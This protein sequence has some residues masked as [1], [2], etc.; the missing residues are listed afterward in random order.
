VRTATYRGL[1]DARQREPAARDIGVQEAPPAGPETVDGAAEILAAGFV[2]IETLTGA[3]WIVRHW[4]KQHRRSV[5]ETRP[6]WLHGQADGRL[7]F[8]RSPWD[9]LS[10]SQVLSVIWAHLPREDESR[11]PEIAGDIFKWSQPRALEAFR[12]LLPSER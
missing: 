3:F 7:R 9:G 10:A 12:A 8:V 11:W 4:P 1:N 5:P 6:E 2:P